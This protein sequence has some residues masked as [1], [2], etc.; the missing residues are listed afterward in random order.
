MERI[1][2]E[3]AAEYLLAHDGYI[4]YNHAMPDG[5]ALGS[6]AALALILRGIG[7]R[8]FA[9]SPDGI[10][11]KYGFLP[12]EGV[13]V[14]SPDELPGYIPLSVDVA[15]PNL[16]GDIKVPVFALS[17]DHHLINT[18]ECERLCLDSG[19]IAAGELI[20]ELAAEL[21]AKI[22]KDIADSL[23]TA[24][25]SDSGGFRYELTSAQTHRIAAEL[26]EAGAD[27][28][29]ICRRLFECKSRAQYEL[30]R[31]AYN[32]LRLTRGGKCAYVVVTKE[33]KDACGAGDGDFDCVNS[34]P[35]ELD[36]VEIS[37]VLRARGN[38]F[39][40][41]LRSSGDTDVSAIAKRYG[42][43]GHY[44]AAGF[45]LECGAEEAEAEIRKIFEE[46]EL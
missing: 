41:S 31:L 22:T 26:H 24:I 1:T 7:K 5:D 12:A 36:G 23:Y 30:L 21:G 35:R 37:A 11:E 19:K 45:T 42:G 46:A 40:V 13:F 27:H 44:H 25:C 14:A 39:K 10:P 28:A 15:G 3:Q 16:L 32:K 43:G 9:F 38:G 17:F 2:V 29:V 34:V 20:Y 33:E 8:A 18:L 4:I 6:A